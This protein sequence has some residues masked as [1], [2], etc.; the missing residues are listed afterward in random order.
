MS[1][2]V[3]CNPV[4]I[5][6]VYAEHGESP[7]CT[8]Y[9]NIVWHPFVCHAAYVTVQKSSFVNRNQNFIDFFHVKHALKMMV[10]S[11]IY[12]LRTFKHSIENRRILQKIRSF[13]Y[14]YVT[15]C[16]PLGNGRTFTDNRKS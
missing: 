5:T 6:T 7:V 10:E 3:Y 11:V 16:L 13:H 8:Y 14:F 15:F 1:A 4:K 12:Q 9:F 2:C